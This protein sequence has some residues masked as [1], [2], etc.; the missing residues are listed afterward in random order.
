MAVFNIW[1]AKFLKIQQLA[2]PC[3]YK[4]APAHYKLYL[5]LSINRSINID[6]DIS[7]VREEK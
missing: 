1:L 4:S 7:H 2:F 6:I 3:H 5:Y